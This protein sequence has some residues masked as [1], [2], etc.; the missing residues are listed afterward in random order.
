MPAT[1]LPAR[2][3]TTTKSSTPARPVTAVLLELVYLMHATKVV[4]Q[5]ET[6]LPR[7][8]QSRSI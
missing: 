6:P 2:R 3:K 1:Q 7:R 5:R 8:S 4:D